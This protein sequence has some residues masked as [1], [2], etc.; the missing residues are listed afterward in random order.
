MVVAPVAAAVASRSDS[1]AS[2]VAP[3]A[4]AAAPPRRRRSSRSSRSTC[5]CLRH[6]ARRYSSPRRCCLLR[7][8]HRCR[9]PPRCH[10]PRS[11]PRHCC[12]SPPRNAPLQSPR[13]QRR[14]CCPCRQRSHCR[15]LHR[16]CPYCLRGA[17]VRVSSGCPCAAC[18][19]DHR[20]LLRRGSSA[21]QPR[22]LRRC[23]W[24][25][26]L[27]RESGEGVPSL[28]IGGPRDR[29][30]IPC[31]CSC[32]RRR[33]GPQRRPRARPRRCHSLRGS[34]SHRRRM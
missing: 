2:I 29:S 21:S 19:H 32:S 18:H 3:R 16:C 14:C 10:F 28:L 12:D 22:S 7:C 25:R 5:C 33:C 34:D 23:Y 27:E 15:Y 11:S 24:S 4:G 6:C 1:S 20:I 17:H 8:C 31:D 30:S 26:C 9:T 13:G